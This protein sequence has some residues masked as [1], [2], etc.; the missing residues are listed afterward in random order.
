VRFVEEHPDH[1]DAGTAVWALGKL[2]DQELTPLF[3][4]IL[5]RHLE[6]NSGTLYQ[7]LIA[8]NNLGID[9]PEAAGSYSIHE[10][11]KNKGM[12]RAYLER[13]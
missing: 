13:K 3:E 8:L 2:F 1:D 5:R 10:V 9:F 6:G 12:A 7:A 11:E 4:S